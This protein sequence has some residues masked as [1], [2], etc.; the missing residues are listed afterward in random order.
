MNTSSMSEPAEV[1][2]GTDPLPEPT[3]DGEGTV[4]VVG[5][6]HVSSDSVD[7]VRERIDEERPDVV[8]V[9]LD[10]GRY[11]QLKGETP[12]DLDSRDLL[13]GNTVFQF[14]AYWMLSYVQTRLGEQF[15]IEPGADMKAGI[16]AAEEHATGVALVDRE[17][18]T[19]MQRFW[20]RLSAGE[21][22][23]MIGG[24]ALGLTDPVTAGVSLG[25]SVGGMFG[26]LAGLAIVPLLGIGSLATVGITG[27]TTLA[28]VGGIVAGAV[29]GGLLGALIVPAVGD[30]PTWIR[31]LVGGGAGIV[32]GVWIAL[33]APSVAGL[34]GTGT[35][36]ELGRFAIRGVIGVIG[37]AAVGG[38]VGLLIGLVVDAVAEDPDELDEEFDI[39][40]LTD[41]DVVTAMME[42]FRRFSPGGAEALIDERDAFI[43]HRLHVLRDAG[44]HVVAIVGAGHRKGIVEYLDHPD[45]LP[46]MESLTGQA[47]SSRFS[48][49]KLFGYLMTLGFAAFFLLL[50]LGGASNAFMLKVFGAWFLFNGVFAFGLARLAGAHLSSCAVGGAVAWLTSLNPLLAPGWFAGYVELRYESVNVADIGRLNEILSDEESPLGD[51]VGQMF[52]VPLFK[53]IMV[54]AMTNIGSFVASMLFPFIVLPWLAPEVGGIGGVADLMWQGLYNGI[55]ILTGVL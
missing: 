19:T 1:A 46:P 39:E 51:L 30:T 31:G 25:I 3:T 21:K 50:I 9:E 20:T 18:Q 29:A 36:V 8:A 43:A 17:I 44:Y 11:R 52:A 37:G 28:L 34:P 35:L 45:R 41:T 47:S 40:S 5:T 55:D 48:V 32:A 38:I 33:T 6:A 7:R 4:T 26:L 27:T 16:E 15:D 53:L 42:E 2:E 22:F 49:Y 24:L 54:V 10:E 12:D 13:R 14:I 23:K